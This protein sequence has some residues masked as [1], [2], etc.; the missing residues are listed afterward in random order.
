MN[1]NEAKDGKLQVPDVEESCRPL[2]YGLTLLAKKVNDDLISTAENP[3]SDPYRGRKIK[4]KAMILQT[5][6]VFN[7][8]LS[9]PGIPRKNMGVADTF[10][11]NRTSTEKAIQNENIADTFNRNIEKPAKPKI[12]N[13][14]P[15]NTFAKKTTATEEEE[16]EPKK[17][18]AKNILADNS[19]RKKTGTKKKQVV[20]KKITKPDTPKKD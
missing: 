10:K 20:R 19:G 12:K 4:A 3:K 11:R 1:L 6:R 15:A 9:L 13:Q 7:V 17:G 14:K 8:R 18:Q 2:V 5:L 16:V